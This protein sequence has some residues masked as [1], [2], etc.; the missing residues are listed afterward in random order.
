MK[1]SISA[2]FPCYNDAGTIASMVELATSTLNK[3]ADDF[4]II[5][6]DDG[7]RDRSRKILKEL[8]S[9]NPYL[10][11]VF[12]EKNKGYG[13]ALQSGFKTAKKD[14]VF[15]TDGD[16]QYDVTELVNLFAKISDK[17]DIVQ[18]YKIKRSDPW[19]RVVIGD[20]YNFGVRLAFN[21]KIKDVDCDFR[22]IRRSVFD[23]VKLVHNSGVITVEMVKKF[24][25]AGFKFA[26]VPVNHYF[27][28]YGRSQFFNFKRIFDVAVEL[29]F[30]WR[31][32]V[33]AKW[34]GTN[35]SKT[36]IF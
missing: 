1:Y 25:D 6:I 8:S 27:R 13:G 3:I 33:L 9:V 18:G 16:A 5:V 19:Y 34:L 32:L 26:Q 36:K 22:L 24:Q 21:I 12:H 14:L 7:S 2:F 20:L 23:K 10:K 30:L 31:E 15:Y 4:E 17:V 35:S 11:L 28:S 29:L